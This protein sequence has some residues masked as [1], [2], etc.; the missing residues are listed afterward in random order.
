MLFDR[1]KFL[2][3]E[4]VMTRCDGDG[5]GEFWV[6]D[7][8]VAEV[9]KLSRTDQSDFDRS[10]TLFTMVAC[11]ENGDAIFSHGDLAKLKAMPQRVLIPMLEMATNACGLS[12]GN[13]PGKSQTSKGSGTG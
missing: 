1:D 11:T 7:I 9:D 12:E 3:T 8:R 6:R 13:E 4:P 10:L 5:F 2:S